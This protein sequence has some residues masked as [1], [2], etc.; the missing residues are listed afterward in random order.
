[1]D[2]ASLN[3]LNQIFQR[4]SA[5]A[6]WKR[7]LEALAT[8]LRG[9]LVFD[10]LA[11]Y[12]VEAGQSG[13]EV[14]Y[15]RAL[16][17]GKS[18]EADAA[19]GESVAA[20]VIASG[21][22]VMQEPPRKVKPNTDRLDLGHLLGLPIQSGPETRGAV[23]FIRFGGPPFDGEHIAT[24]ALAA[25]WISN[26][27]ERRQW[28][29][30]FQQL[31]EVQR[32]VRLQDD[33]VATISHELRTPL[34]FIKGYSTTLL[35]Q[36]TEWDSATQREFLTIIDEE[37]DRLTQL[38]EDL[39]ESARLQ[40]NT[41]RFK[42][43]QM[44]ID[45]L[46]RDVMVRI[47]QRH[48][49]LAVELDFGAVRPIPGDTV[50][51]ARVFDNLFQNAVRY[52]PG[53]PLQIRVREED[54]HLHVQFIDHGP[55]IPAEHLAMIFERFYRVP[56]SERAANTGTGLGLFICKQIVAAHRGKIWAESTRG[57]GTTFHIEL[58]AVM[59]PGQ[60]A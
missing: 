15:A 41:L 56:N 49:N 1:M 40:S 52:A 10:N 51:L 59:P 29:E 60:S 2:P 13:L 24:A 46:I 35:R 36:D 42:F 43:Q 47:R 9:P 19:W 45:A 14:H 22:P 6:D 30:T 16:G 11:V 7:A 57:Q 8:D 5:H 12:L 20:Q 58:P 37:T 25:A 50:H 38:I 17:R 39:L 27:L 55:G 4:A 34:G 48:P 3:S 33:F 32:R 44:R 23:V 18:A 28:H 26:L 53:S 31:Q 54:A 21:N